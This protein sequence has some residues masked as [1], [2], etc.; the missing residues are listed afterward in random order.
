M[1]LLLI[2]KKTIL[3]DYLGGRNG[4]NSSSNRE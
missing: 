1:L 2:N 4:Q 3:I